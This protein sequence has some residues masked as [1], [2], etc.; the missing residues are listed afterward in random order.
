MIRGAAARAV[1]GAGLALAVG[2][3]VAG[4]SAPPPPTPSATVSPEPSVVA[5]PSPTE[6]PSRTAPVEPTSTN[7]LPPPPPPS[8]PAPSTASDLTAASLPVP[9]GWR[10]VALAGSEEEGFEGNG[11]WVHARDPRY[12]AYDVIGIGC[13]SVTRD[14]YTDPVAALEGNYESRTGAPGIGL[15]L[16]FGGVADANRFFE[17][18]RQ[19]VRACTRSDGSVRTT[20]VSE[21]DGL[22][23]RRTYPDSEWTEIAR[24]TGSRVTMI[25][26]TDPGH[27]ISRAATRAILDQFP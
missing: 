11:T 1:R 18:Y 22:V 12:A 26:L 23:D 9:A 20:I 19:Q 16:E 21:T 6:A 15:V 24:Q 3:I 5:S 14:E 27:R 8:G 7:T 2:L 13:R 4:C 17:L 10:T 25:I